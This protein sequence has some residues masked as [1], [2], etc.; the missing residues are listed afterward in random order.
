MRI[1]FLE[2]CFHCIY[3]RF[4][5]LYIPDKCYKCLEFQFK[6][7]LTNIFTEFKGVRI[8]KGERE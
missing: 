8:N 3:Y 2:F 1:M 4:N 6:N 5:D 7:R